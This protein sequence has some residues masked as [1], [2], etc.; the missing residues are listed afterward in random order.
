MY[1]YP[2]IDL[3]MPSFGSGKHFA[4]YIHFPIPLHCFQPMEGD[5]S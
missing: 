1:V 3:A 5:I 2:E 4:K